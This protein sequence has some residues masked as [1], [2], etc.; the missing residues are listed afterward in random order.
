MADPHAGA[1]RARASS[2]LKAKS[3]TKKASVQSKKAQEDALKKTQ[4]Q[5]ID[6]YVNEQLDAGLKVLT[7]RM[8]ASDLTPRLQLL[9]G[10]QKLCRLANDLFRA[11][12]RDRFMRFSNY[13]TRDRTADKEEADAEL[14]D[15]D[16]IIC[17][18]SECLPGVR[19][20]E[21]LQVPKSR[22][23]PALFAALCRVEDLRVREPRIKQMMSFV[24][25]SSWEDQSLIITPQFYTPVLDEAGKHKRVDGQLAYDL[26]IHEL[27]QCN[28]VIDS[29]MF[30][31][32]VGMSFS[33]KSQSYCIEEG[34]EDDVLEL[35]RECRK[36]GGFIPGQTRSIPAQPRLLGRS[37]QKA[38]H[39]AA[40]I[41]PTK[42]GKRKRGQN[43]SAAIEPT[44][45]IKPAKRKQ[46][47]S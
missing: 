15:L 34:W 18:F 21:V 43:T 38:K 2:S 22:A 23:G 47:Q 14:S 5:N 7:A 24:P 44:K 37:K 46:G 19:F 12:L 41:E 33:E 45:L 36:K 10:I 16:E 32:R 11:Q 40:A 3:K 27:E 13:N 4:R 26:P 9:R 35:L 1:T 8:E 20:S 28:Q 6:K 39:T 30:L 31:K 29:S 25:R 17:V 42:L